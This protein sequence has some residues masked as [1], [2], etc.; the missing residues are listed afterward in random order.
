MKRDKELKTY[1]HIQASCT[2][3]LAFI[4]QKTEV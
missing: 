3:V 1:K 4:C 2:D